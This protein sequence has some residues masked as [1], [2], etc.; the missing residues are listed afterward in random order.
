MNE[1][2]QVNLHFHQSKQIRSYSTDKAELRNLLEILQERA[3][4][5]YDIEVRH[6]YKIEQQNEGGLQE[7]KEDLREGFRLFITLSGADGTKLIGNIE[8]IF[9]SPNF[10]ED[11]KD[12]YFDTGTLLQNRHNYYPRNRIVLVIDFARPPVLNFSILP[13]LAT[14]NESSITVNGK[15]VTWVNGVFQEILSHVSHHPSTLPW[16]HRHSVYDL[17]VWVFGLPLAFWICSKISHSIE[18]NLHMYSPFL[19]SALYVYI[20]MLSLNLLRVAFH[21]ARWIWPLTEFRCSRNR[22]LKHKAV[23]F[24]I[25]TGIASTI[26]CDFI[27][28]L[29]E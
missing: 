6:L 12:I 5:A 22:S 23:F 19:R 21:Y 14:D 20:F 7:A 2:N 26:I 16:L 27:K 18:N 9:D 25:C 10:P 28:L 17:L 3:Y 13:S 24:A 11:V 8:E 1:H 29:V 15:D 4:A